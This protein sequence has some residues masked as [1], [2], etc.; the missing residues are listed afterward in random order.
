MHSLCLPQVATLDSLYLCECSCCSA[1]TPVL[2]SHRQR[3]Q[4]PASFRL[5]AW[6]A[7]LVASSSVLKVFAAG[8]VAHRDR[9]RESK[10]VPVT[11]SLQVLTFNS[12]D[13][14]MGKVPLLGITIFICT[15]VC[16]LGDSDEDITGIG[17][18]PTSRCVE[19]PV[20][21]RRFRIK[22]S[23][24]VIKPWIFSELE[25]FASV[26]GL[27]LDMPNLEV[28]ERLAF[29]SRRRLHVRDLELKTPRLEHIDPHAFDRISGVEDLKIDS[30]LLE[31]PLEALSAFPELEKLEIEGD[32]TQLPIGALQQHPNLRKVDLE[33]TSIQWLFTRAFSGLSRLD[34]SRLPA[35]AESC[36]STPRSSSTVHWN[37]ERLTF[38]ESRGNSFCFCRRFQRHAGYVWKSH[39]GEPALEPSSPPGT[40][41]GSFEDCY[42]PESIFNKMCQTDGATTGRLR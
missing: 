3:P 28:L 29:E 7:K 6:L 20:T 18:D 31:Y 35:S 32:F 11:S 33:E 37:C 21:N 15:L 12:A 27:V 24:K 17:C 4:Q 13:H 9:E 39:L 38:E 25:D 19:G 16:V 22:S 23:A 40:K 26:G 36:S 10:G 41:T 34:S 5:T 30:S 8:S 14:T 42:P 1:N 2:S